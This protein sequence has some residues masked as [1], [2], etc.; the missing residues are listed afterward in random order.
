MENNATLTKWDSA[1]LIMLV[2]PVMGHV[3]M[4]P[5]ILDIAGR[6]AW[7]SALLSLPFALLYG[8][9][10]YRLRL[11]FA[12]TDFRSF[13]RSVMGKFAGTLL[14]MAFSLYFAFLCIM[15]TVQL[16]D[17]VNICF[18]PETPN[19][20]LTCL[21]LFI[22]LYAAAKGIKALAL[23]SAVLSLFAITIGYT[24]S[25]ASAPMKD[26]RNLYPLLEYGWSPVWLGCLV[27]LSVWMELAF[28]L[29]IPLRNA[30][31]KSLFRMWGICIAWNMLIMM[32]TI[33]GVIAVFGLGQASNFLY[34]ALEMVRIISLGFIDRFDTY[35]LVLMSFGCYIRSS[36]YLR[37]CCDLIMPLASQKKQRFL[38]LAI[39]AVVLACSL[40][41]AN[42]HIR[43]RHFS[44]LDV[45]G[46]ALFP[47]LALLLGLSWLKRKRLSG[48]SPG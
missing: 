4:L 6:D 19:L 5:L 28:L 24:V 25:I 41:I 40:Y 46:I 42:T 30:A 38:L 14:L 23:T 13:A 31:D 39:W 9:V 47:L 2:L 18:L 1:F 20:A 33:S 21:F 32:M 12:K 34:P 45:Y 36:L 11:Q 15:S 29:V 26:W 22:C 10:I 37:L 35:A 43:V 8:Y 7:L 3:I 27:L 48:G 16:V 44:L 17:M